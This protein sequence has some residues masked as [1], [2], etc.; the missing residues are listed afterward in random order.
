MSKVETLRG[1]V[2]EE[3]E[4]QFLQLCEEIFALENERKM[5]RKLEKPHLMKEKKK[6]RARVL[7]ILDEKGRE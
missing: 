4:A 7:T 5:Q 3:L 2:K 6:Q 1:C